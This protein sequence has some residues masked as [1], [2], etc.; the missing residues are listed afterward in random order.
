MKIRI[1]RI[2]KKKI[3]VLI[4]LFLIILF[5]LFFNTKIVKNDSM[6]PV[7]R[8]NYIVF[9]LPFFPIEKGYIYGFKHNN[10]IYVKRLI[11]CENDIIEIKSGKIFIN[12]LQYNDFYV[13]KLE[14][15]GPLILNKNEY[16]FLGD[17][18]LE[19]LDSRSFGVIKKKDLKFRV[20]FILYPFDKTGFLK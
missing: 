17:Y 12:Y 2:L 15:F 16:F 1:E 3:F 20:I 6:S 13:N 19:S 5:F 10:K 11:G 4:I 8:N 18:I 7:L 14:K 9:T